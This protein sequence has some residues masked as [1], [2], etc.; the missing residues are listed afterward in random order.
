MFCEALRIDVMRRVN[1]SLILIVLF[2]FAC[3]S[4]AKPSSAPTGGGGRIQKR[5]LRADAAAVATD[6]ANRQQ[7]L[8]QT[9]IQRIDRG[10]QFEVDIPAYLLNHRLVDHQHILARGGG[11]ADAHPAS[12]IVH[13]YN[14]EAV[15]IDFSA[16]FPESFARNLPADIQDVL[17]ED[18]EVD[19]VEIFFTPQFNIRDYVA[20]RLGDSA[21]KAHYWLVE[22]TPANFGGL[23][24]QDHWM[25]IFDPDYNIDRHLNAGDWT[26]VNVNIHDQ[27]YSPPGDRGGGL[28]FRYAIQGGGREDVQPVSFWSVVIDHLNRR[29]AVTLHWILPNQDQTVRDGFVQALNQSA[30]RPQFGAVVQ[31][32]SNIPAF[33]GSPMIRKLQ[34]LIQI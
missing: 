27:T 3:C 24:N 34:Q 19:E 17:I 9:L 16:R 31:Q 11:R 1:L 6:Q 32:W 14:W 21:L 5:F 4:K 18:P 23:Y 30:G 12:P 13:T 29:A 20:D 22:Q 2:S 25:M 10:A 8:S 28:N 15:P 7:F 33:A 26:H